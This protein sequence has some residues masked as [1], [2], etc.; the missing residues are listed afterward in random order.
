MAAVNHFRLAL[1]ADANDRDT[2][3]GLG[4]SLRLAGQ[5]AAAVPYL[6]AARARDHLEW[7]VQNARSSFEHDDPRSLTALGDACRSLG[8]VPEAQGWYR[9]ALARDPLSGDIQ[10]RL[11][12]LDAKL[13]ETAK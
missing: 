5:A 8:R 9:L 11:F 3:F 4:Q 12:E 13:N 6:E 10:K 7:L 1:A 2:L